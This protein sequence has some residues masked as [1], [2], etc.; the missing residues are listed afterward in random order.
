VRNYLIFETNDGSSREET[1][2]I[3]LSDDDEA[4]TFGQQVIREMMQVASHWRVYQKA[5]RT[6]VPPALPQVRNTQGGDREPSRSS[7]S[8][9]SHRNDEAGS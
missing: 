9:R 6:V 7:F 2:Q 4:I 8:A 3:E 5:V 1:G